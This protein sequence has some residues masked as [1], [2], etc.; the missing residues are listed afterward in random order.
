MAIRPQKDT[1]GDRTRVYSSS[2]RFTP[3]CRVA[4]GIQEADCF[5]TVYARKMSPSRVA[6]TGVKAG[7]GWGW[8]AG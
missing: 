5:L 7:G 3:E 4:E 1:L 6:E 2:V 8:G